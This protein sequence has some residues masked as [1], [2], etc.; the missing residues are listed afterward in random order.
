MINLP[1]VEYAYLMEDLAEVISIHGRQFFSLVEKLI[2][3]AS[4]PEEQEPR[5]ESPAA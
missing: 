3:N 5:L 4:L 2:I 1:D